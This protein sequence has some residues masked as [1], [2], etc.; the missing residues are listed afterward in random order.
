MVD[1]GQQRLA[2]QAALVT[3]ASSGLG[4]AVAVE[5]ASQG[6]AVA[7][8]ARDT[9]ALQDVAG[10]VDR[11]GS[12]ALPVAAD[13]ADEDALTGAVRFCLQP[14]A[15]DDP[16]QRRRYR[17]PWPRGGS[18]DVRL[19]PRARRPLAC[20]LSAGAHELPADARRG[21]RNDHQRFIGGWKTGV[22]QRRRL[23]RVEVRASWLDS[24]T[25]R[26]GEAPWHS[27]LPAGAGRHGE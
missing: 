3:G 11:L 27:S 9:A 6:A 20:A 18:R 24:G 25:C 23:L 14:G 13:L 17:R 4:R 22:G 1:G 15:I 26:R 16:G 5:L 21:P 19:G 7:L 8:L 10:E 2:G 12:V